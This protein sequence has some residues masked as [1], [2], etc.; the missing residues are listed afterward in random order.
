[1]FFISI[2]AKE[3]RRSS[4]DRRKSNGLK[5]SGQEKRRRS[6]RRSNKD[7]RSDSE[8]RSGMYYRLSDNQK[9]TMDNIINILEM[10]RMKKT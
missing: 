6:D 7:R 4:G 5:Y 1:M 2:L 9:E 8:R 3:K 10:E